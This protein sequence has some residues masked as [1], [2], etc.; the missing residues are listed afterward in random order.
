MHY[1]LRRCVWIREHEGFP[2]YPSFSNAD[3]AITGKTSELC[4]CPLAKEAYL[5]SADLWGAFVS[6]QIQTTPIRLQFSFVTHYAPNSVQREGNFAKKN[7]SLWE[8]L[9]NSSCKIPIR[10]QF[11]FAHVSHVWRLQPWRRMKKKLVQT[12][13]LMRKSSLKHWRRL[14]VAVN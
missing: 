13:C 11:S 5:Q 9:Q 7:S 8:T 12:S 14:Q 3:F 2:S 4:C 10:L 1:G 6:R